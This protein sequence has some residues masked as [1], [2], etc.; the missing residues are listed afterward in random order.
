[1]KYVTKPDGIYKIK[2]CSSGGR[3]IHYDPVEYYESE[4]F[5][6]STDDL[7]GLEKQGLI[8]INYKLEEKQK[9]TK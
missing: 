3:F 1:M 7:R 5:L 8:K 6:I 4:I 2:L 9:T